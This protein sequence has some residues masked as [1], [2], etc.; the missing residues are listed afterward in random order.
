MKQF[1]YELCLEKIKEAGIPKEHWDTAMIYQAMLLMN[2][3]AECPPCLR[4]FY[5]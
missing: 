2:P 5:S 3:N 4:P 1:Y